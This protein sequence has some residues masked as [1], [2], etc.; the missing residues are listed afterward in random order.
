MTRHSF[1]FGHHYD[2]ANIS[3]GPVVAVNDE[4]LAPGAGF[5]DH[6]HSGLVIVT[7]VVAGSLA[8][9]RISSRTVSAGQAAV[10][11]CGSGVV[12]AERNAGPDEL[13]FVQTWLTASSAAPALPSYE[14]LDLEGLTEVA[15]VDGARVLAGTVD[16]GWSGE[17]PSGHAFVAA[18]ACDAAGTTLV[19]GDS[20]R[21][22]EPVQLRAAEDGTALV[23]VGGWQ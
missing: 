8:H 17:L 5:D 20:L 4:V 6:P 11:R 10:L 18:G 14:V 19:A 16:A 1:S 15:V 13:R 2:P 7:L 12:H 23:L 3:F 22:G 9:Q 21:S